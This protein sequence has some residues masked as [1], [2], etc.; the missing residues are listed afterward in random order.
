MQ[1]LPVWGTGERKVLS[2][3]HQ[4]WL[5]PCAFPELM[6]LLEPATQKQIPKARKQPLHCW[7]HPLS[8]SFFSCHRTNVDD[9]LIAPGDF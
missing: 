2:L 6:G 5:L 4:A 7:G 3:F 1:K 9:K 8:F